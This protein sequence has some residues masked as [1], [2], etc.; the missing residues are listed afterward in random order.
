MYKLISNERDHAQEQLNH[1][2]QA[3]KELLAIHGPE[4]DE[5]ALARLTEID[6]Q[7]QRHRDELTRLFV[8]IKRVTGIQKSGTGGTHFFLNQ[9]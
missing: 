2:L 6:R 7:A 8:L 5:D 4:P 9:P 1:V 3:R